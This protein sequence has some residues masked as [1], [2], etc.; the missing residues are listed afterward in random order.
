[1]FVIHLM[2]EGGGGGGGV[3]CGEKNCVRIIHKKKHKVATEGIDLFVIYIYI[4]I[5]KMHR[6]NRHL[7]HYQ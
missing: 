5:V 1:M 3:T 2:M 6:A 7:L 4:Y